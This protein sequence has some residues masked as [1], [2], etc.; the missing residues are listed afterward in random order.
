MW[1]SF[2][3]RRGFFDLRIATR[4][5]QIGSK[6]RHGHF[7]AVCTFSIP[8]YFPDRFLINLLLQFDHACDQSLRSWRTARDINVNGQEFV[9]SCDNVVSLLE[10]TAARGAGAH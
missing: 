8:A 6:D 4:V 7:H 9:N 2:L 1:L 5:D 3:C 10:W